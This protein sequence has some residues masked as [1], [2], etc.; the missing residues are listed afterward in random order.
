MPESSASLLAS[1]DLY[2]AA[3]VWAALAPLRAW[4]RPRFVGLEHLEGP[5]PF[6][7]VANHT[8]FGTLDILTAAGLSQHAGIRARGLHAPLYGHVPGWSGVLRRLGGVSATGDNMRAL[9]AAGESPLVCPGGLREVAKRRGEKYRLLW[10][11]RV[12][13]VRNAA[14]HGAPLVALATVGPEDAY[15][16]VLDA[17]QIERSRA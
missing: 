14:R 13:W 5:G 11:D 17:G 16:I 7:F 2:S 9:L 10:G 12:G 6:V 8:L 4:F 1:A 15:T 3:S